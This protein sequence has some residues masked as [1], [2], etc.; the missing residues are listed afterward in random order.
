MPF[1]APLF[2][3]IAFIIAKMKA[4]RPTIGPTI[5][6]RI[7]IISTTPAATSMSSISKPWFA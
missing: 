4:A 6:P 7:G 2:A 1:L 3:F 5:Q